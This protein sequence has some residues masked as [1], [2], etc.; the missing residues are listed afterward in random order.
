MRVAQVKRKRGRPSVHSTELMAIVNQMYPDVKSKRGK[1]DVC[2]TI[3]AVSALLDGPALWF[4]D[5][6]SVRAGVPTTMHGSLMA[7]LGRFRHDGLIREI[8]RQLD[9]QGPMQIREA[10]KLVRFVRRAHASSVARRLGNEQSNGISATVAGTPS[11]GD[12]STD[13]SAERAE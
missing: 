9:E 8:A 3:T 10:V 2:D 6:P 1:L 4:Y 12:P 13:G 5:A 11:A 7:E